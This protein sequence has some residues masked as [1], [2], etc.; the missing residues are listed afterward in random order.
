MV[1]VQVDELLRAAAPLLESLHDGVVAVDQSGRVLFVNEANHRI[2]GLQS[3]QLLGKS[4][5]EVVPESHLPQVL[6]SGEPLVGVRTRVAGREV[7]SNIVPLW[8]GERV[9]GAISIFRDLTELLALSAQLQEA[10]NTID[11][12]RQYLGSDPGA[13]EG[14]VLGR[15]PAAGRA[16]AMA[17]RAA[18][19]SSP[20]LIEGESGTG[21]EV[22]A[23]LIHSRS[24]RA[25]KPFIAF[26]CAAV[27]ETLLES[28]LFGH[29]EGAFTGA[30]RGGR[31]GLMEMADGG[32]L[33]LDEVGDMEQGVQAKLL[34]ALQNGE[35][36]RL[37]GSEVRRADVRVISATNRPLRDLIEAHRFR[38]DLYYRLRVI[39]IQV[40]PLRTRREDLSQFIDHALARVCKRLRRPRPAVEPGAL[41]LLLAYDY[42]GNIR[43][44]ENL[45]EQAVVLDDDDV[46][47]EADL[48]SELGPPGGGV[49][50]PETLLRFA[51]GYPDWAEAERALLAEG[52]RRFP[53]RS[54]LAVHLGIGR[55]TLYRKLAHHGLL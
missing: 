46:I 35:F 26:N 27:P 33:F 24:D 28:E 30:R 16:F 6:A 34:R 15:S 51:G 17:V 18:A 48:P 41:R 21:K 55:A 43:E 22:M 54:A 50:G 45:V 49:I 25:L 31:A 37:G 8:E 29:E 1:G 40:P 11:L 5:G 42:P 20:V 52:L 38:E 3:N 7:V 36:R 23:R 2:T 13:P 32:T 19:V 47:G 12:L 10:R 44:L 9:A 14:V 4:A 53:S 39:R